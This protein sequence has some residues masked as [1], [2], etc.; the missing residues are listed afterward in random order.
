M[1]RAHWLN[2]NGEWQFANATA[3]Q[4]PPFGQNLAESVL[5]PFPIESALSGIQ[6]HQDRMWYR[7]TFTVP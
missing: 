6:R 3:G 4:T 7:R 1:V 5:V 2:L